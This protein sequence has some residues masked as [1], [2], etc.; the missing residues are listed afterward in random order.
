MEHALLE[1]SC[2][3]VIRDEI[4]K[5]EIGFSL[6]LSLQAFEPWLGLRPPGFITNIQH[7]QETKNSIN[8]DTVHP[9]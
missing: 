1:G 8:R 9:L 4:L 3:L 5:Y 6:A 7:K 2:K